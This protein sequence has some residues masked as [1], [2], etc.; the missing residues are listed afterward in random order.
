MSMVLAGIHLA[1]IVSSLRG[2]D[3]AGKAMPVHSAVKCDQVLDA[4]DKL[5]PCTISIEA[6][7]GSHH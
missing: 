4:V 5:P 7:S 3:E 6:C 1:K 2:V